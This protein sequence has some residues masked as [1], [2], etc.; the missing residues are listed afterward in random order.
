MKEIFNKEQKLFERISWQG[1]SFPVIP[2]WQL[3]Q[4]EGDINEGSIFIGYDNSPIIHLKWYR[5][6]KKS[7]D[8]QS[9]ILQK[10]K[11]NKP[12]KSPPLPESFLSSAWKLKHYLNEREYLNIWIGVGNDNKT[13]VEIISSNLCSSPIQNLISNEL[14]PNTKLFSENE[15]WI[16]R[17]GSASFVSPKKFILN[18]KYLACGDISLEFAGENSQILTLRQIY[19]AKLALTRKSLADWQNNRPFEEKLKIFKVSEEN[20]QDIQ[21]KI[22]GI[23][24]KTIKKLPVPLQHFKSRFSELISAHDEKSDKVIISEFS[25][26]KNFFKEGFSYN[27]LVQSIKEIRTNL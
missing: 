18:R 19:P 27:Y 3:L 7:P 21:N 15:D 24:L 20:F 25:A 5:S 13:I 9:W 16:W 26:E 17:I 14:I 1:I 12:D 11:I 2:E 23:K 10:F 6:K 4:I 22:A 8:A